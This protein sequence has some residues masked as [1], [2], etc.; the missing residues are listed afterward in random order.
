LAPVEIPPSVSFPEP[1]LESE[2]Q[3]AHC[4][5]DQEKDETGAAFAPAFPGVHASSLR[6]K[7]RNSSRKPSGLI[8]KIV[9]PCPRNSAANR[10]ASRATIYRRNRPSVVAETTSVE[11]AADKPSP[12][13]ITRRNS[14]R[15]SSSRDSSSSLPP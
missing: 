3:G 12:E 9:A 2:Q 15:I 11:D 6:T 14:W 1:W 4:K 7:W 13:A 5:H 8:S 10:S